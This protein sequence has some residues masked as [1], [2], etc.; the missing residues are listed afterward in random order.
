MANLFGIVI[1]TRKRVLRNLLVLLV[2]NQG[3]DFLATPWESITSDDKSDAQIQY[4]SNMKEAALFASGSL[5]AWQANRKL[6][7]MGVT[8]SGIAAVAVGM[9]FGI[10]LAGEASSHFWGDEGLESWYDFHNRLYTNRT[11]MDG[12][13]VLG[14]AMTFLPNPLGVLE[15]L[16]LPGMMIGEEWNAGEQLREDVLSMWN[17]AKARELGAGIRF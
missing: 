3:S 17:S 11:S 16:F 15:V 2:K 10:A 6:T 12:V 9:Y 13:P 7:A 5:I 14:E 4:E 1:P 8:K